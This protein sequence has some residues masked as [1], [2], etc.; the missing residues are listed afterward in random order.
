MVNVTAD[1]I[2]RSLAR[3]YNLCPGVV[4][5][6]DEGEVTATVMARK[7]PGWK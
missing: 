6:G 5:C 4:S 1:H 3:L 7:M 2:D